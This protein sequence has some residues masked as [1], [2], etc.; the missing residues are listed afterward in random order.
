M[1]GAI[2]VLTGFGAGVVAGC[3]IE[4]YRYVCRVW[5]KT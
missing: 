1:T 4:L 3:L 2:I 5:V